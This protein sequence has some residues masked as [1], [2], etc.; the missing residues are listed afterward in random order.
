MR[1]PGAPLRKSP[2][3]ELVSVGFQSR[4]QATVHFDGRRAARLRLDA[5][6]RWAIQ[7]RG[8][9]FDTFDAALDWLCTPPGAPLSLDLS[10]PKAHP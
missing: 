3:G 9:A 1:L 7:P 6:G 10:L 8:P 4:D 2:A 5:A